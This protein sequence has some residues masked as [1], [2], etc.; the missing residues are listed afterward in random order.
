M[1]RSSGSAV[2][3]DSGH[4]RLV[5]TGSRAAAANIAMDAAQLRLRSEG[6]ISN[7]IRILSFSSPAALIGMH[8]SREQEVREAYCREKGIEVNRRITGGGAVYCDSGQLGWE[9]IASRD[10]L[11][12]GRTM[13]DLTR[14]ICGGAVDALRLLGVAAAFRP[15]NDIEVEGRKICGTGGAYERGAFL[16][17]GTLLVDFDPGEMLRALR[18]PVE[19]LSRRELEDAGRRVVSLS[20]LLGRVPGRDEVIEAFRAAFSRLLD[21]DIHRQT[22]SAME[23]ERASA[24]LAR[25]RS[26]QWIDNDIEPASERLMLRSMHRGPGGVINASIALDSGSM[27]LKGVNISG[28]FFVDPGRFIYDLE[29]GLRDCP[30]DRLEERVEELFREYSPD[31]LGLDACDFSVALR[32]AV[33]KSCYSR[34]GIAPGYLDDITVIGDGSLQDIAG[35]TRYLLLPYCAKLPG[36]RY[37]RLDGCEEC[38]DC[39]VGEAYALARKHGLTPVSVNDYGHLRETLRRCR[40]AG[41]GAII[42]CCCSQFTA[43]H[44]ETFQSCGMDV[45]LLDISDSTCYELSRQ[46]EAYM[47]RF[48]EQTTLKLELLE[49]VLSLR[50]SGDRVPPTGPLVDEPPRRGGGASRSISCDVL[51]I[52]AGPAGSAAARAAAAAGA[53]VLMLERRR[54]V[55]EPPQCAGYIPLLAGRYADITADMVGQR[56]GEMETI[57]PNGSRWV[58][59]APGYI[60]R[61]DLFDQHQAA[62]ACQ[63]GARLFEGCHARPHDG[64][65]GA[66]LRDG[67]CLEISSRVTIGADGPRSLTRELIGG[68]PPRLMRA[69]QWTVPLKRPVDRTM[70]WFERWLPMGYGWLFPRGETANAG[71]GIEAG[72]GVKTPEALECFIGMLVERGL[73]EAVPLASTAGVIPAGGP[74]PPGRG[75]ILLAG[76]AAGLCNARTGAGVVTALQSGLYAGDAAVRFLAGDGGSAFDLYFAEVSEVLW[77]TLAMAADMRERMA[78][79]TGDETGSLETAVAATWPGSPGYGAG[80]AERHREGVLTRI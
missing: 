12:A 48:A 17:Q 80:M 70:V 27:R 39:T 38:G 47:G 76:D 61:R 10:D 4:W 59:R 9:V 73:V 69:M 20:R 25:Y 40:D 52:G 42:G 29:A 57:L 7:T 58:V 51:V 62:R 15:R 13:A 49:Q 8:Q 6:L 31:C 78:S 16:F 36:C 79:L 41:E 11:P 26:R 65:A 32:R 63:A 33:E 37:R 35:R 43:K 19:K 30:S 60:I 50:S 55:G 34:L 18:V 45:V 71:I 54:R 53:S 68:A 64:G 21:T 74:L 77:P 23:E 46:E 2:D 1:S 44:H 56:V 5:D 75:N 67:R 14:F 28:D 22:L 72:N 3:D 24:M 66:L